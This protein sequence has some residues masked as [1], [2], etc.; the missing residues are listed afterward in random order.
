MLLRLVPPPTPPPL[1]PGAWLPRSPVTGVSSVEATSRGD[2]AAYA[3]L[4]GRNTQPYG[5]GWRQQ[6][7]HVLA[8]APTLMLLLH[9]QAWGCSS[10]LYEPG[11]VCAMPFTAGST[12]CSTSGPRCPLWSQVQLPVPPTVATAGQLSCI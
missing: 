1:P 10:A 9:Q 6:R 8:A 5:Q 7:R 11:I 4:R 2:C 3:A 12:S